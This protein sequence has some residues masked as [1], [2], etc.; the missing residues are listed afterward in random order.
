MGQPQPKGAAAKQCSIQPEES[1][2]G[3]ETKG[4]VTGSGLY[5]KFCPKEETPVILSSAQASYKKVKSPDG[6][7]Y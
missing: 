3:Q 4:L 5:V 2:R 6:A 7:P 1:S